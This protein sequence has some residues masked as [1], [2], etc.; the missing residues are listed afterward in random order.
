VYV[1]RAIW[2]GRGNIRY[3]E[4]ISPGL[5]N[6]GKPAESHASI[7]ANVLYEIQGRLADSPVNM[8]YCHKLLIL[9]LLFVLL[10]SKFPPLQMVILLHFYTTLFSFS[11]GTVSLR[12]SVG[13]EKLVGH[14]S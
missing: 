2:L 14:I 12:H 6:T 11:S 7:E 3:V 5:E 10:Q 9:V 1:W 13:V 4:T 8:L